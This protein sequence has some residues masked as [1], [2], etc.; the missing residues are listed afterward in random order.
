MDQSEAGGLYRQLGRLI[1]T[2]PVF[3]YG[4]DLGPNEFRWMARSQAILEDVGDILDRT[5]F[6]VAQSSLNTQLGHER[7]VQSM[8]MALYRAMARLERELPEGARGSFIPVGNSFDAFT[9]FKRI[10]DGAKHDLFVVDPYMDET[11]LTDFVSLV[12]TGITIRLLADSFG[13][14]PPLAVAARKWIDQF[15]QARPL[16]LRLAAERTLHDRAIFIDRATAWTVTQSLKDFA[17]R[18][19]GEFIN[20]A[21]TA[22]LKIAAYEQIWSDSQPA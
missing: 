5:D 6:R 15:G 16:E 9:A 22:R 10:V 20:A 13:S 17:K 14:K 18:S 11:I 21:D 3:Q 4:E 19:P 1:E 7:A 12:P 2:M 8:I